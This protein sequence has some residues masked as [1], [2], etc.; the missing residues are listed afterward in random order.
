MS[1]QRVSDGVAEGP[2]GTGGP[3]GGF[4]VELSGSVVVGSQEKA[5]TIMFKV[6]DRA[7]VDF[8]DRAKQYT[9]SFTE[10]A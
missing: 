8:F 4:T 10:S 5:A 1:P 9:V 7:S 2:Q 3:V 6:A